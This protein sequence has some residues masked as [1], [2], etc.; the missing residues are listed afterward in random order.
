MIE[1]PPLYNNTKW[2]V[3]MSRKFD[4]RKFLQSVN[5]FAILHQ[6]YSFWV[7][8][9]LSVVLLSLCLKGQTFIKIGE[10]WSFQNNIRRRRGE[11]DGYANQKMCA[12]FSRSICL[13]MLYS[14][15]ATLTFCTFEWVE[16]FEKVELLHLK[17]NFWAVKSKKSYVKTE[18]VLQQ[19][20]NISGQ[21]VHPIKFFKLCD[22]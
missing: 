2:L 17:P 1:P 6:P 5:I 4:R 10:R 16:A 3:S 20:T 13:P 8:P 19:N 14:S 22:S 11:D 9:D 21:N 15:K 12:I 7:Y 18:K